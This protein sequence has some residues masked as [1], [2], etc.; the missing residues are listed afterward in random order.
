MKIISK[1]NL[2]FAAQLAVAGILGLLVA[3]AFRLVKPAYTSG[4]YSSYFPDKSVSV[5]MYGTAWWKYCTSTREFLK[6]QKV[7]FVEYDVE[8]SAPAK[9]QFDQLN[10]ESFPL[11]LIGDR[12]ITG[13]APSEFE[14]ALRALENP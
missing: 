8:K 9:A 2:R 14:S 11:L 4:D 12:K 5:V 7:R 1:S 13:F 3:Y 10:G 6:Q